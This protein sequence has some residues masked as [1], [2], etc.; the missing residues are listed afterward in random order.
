MPGGLPGG[1]TGTVPLATRTTPV[2]LVQRPMEPQGP[3]PWHTSA[4][5]SHRDR[6]PGKVVGSSLCY[7]NCHLPNSFRLNIIG[8]THNDGESPAE[9]EPRECAPGWKAHIPGRK[10]PASRVRGRTSQDGNSAGSPRY[11]A[12]R[13]N[14][15]L[16]QAR[17]YREAAASP[18]R[19]AGCFFA[20]RRGRTARRRKSYEGKEPGIQTF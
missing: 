4:R 13:R 15:E 7:I 3:S 6:P 11:R 17:W 19:G 20:K 10:A 2:H 18:L 12:E 9:G 16:F 5:G 1:A 8:H 14:R